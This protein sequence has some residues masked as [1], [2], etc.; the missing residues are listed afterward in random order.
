MSA[1]ETAAALA[2]AAGQNLVHTV[3]TH[4]PASAQAQQ[5]ASLADTA[6]THAQGTGCTPADYQAARN[7]R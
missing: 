4:G 5:A 7:N 2:V 1:K 3:T 6:L